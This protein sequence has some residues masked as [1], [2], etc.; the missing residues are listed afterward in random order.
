MVTDL[1][2]GPTRLVSYFTEMAEVS[3]GLIGAFS[4]FGLSAGV[5]YGEFA[6]AVSALS[7]GAVIVYFFVDRNHWAV[8]DLL[9]SGKAGGEDEEKGVNEVFHDSLF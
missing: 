5:G 8:S 3:P 2:M 7:D 4:H 1:L 6:S 9:R